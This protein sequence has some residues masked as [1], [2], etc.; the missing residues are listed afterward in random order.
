MRELAGALREWA[1]DEGLRRAAGRACRARAEALFT[2]ERMLGEYAALV[3][4]LC[5]RGGPV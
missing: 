1:R 3:D 5:G 4:R 2:E